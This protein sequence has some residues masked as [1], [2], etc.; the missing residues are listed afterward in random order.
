MALIV[1]NSDGAIEEIQRFGIGSSSGALNIAAGLEIPSNK[2]HTVVSL[3]SGSIL[4]EIKAEPF[5]PN[6]P[7]Y[8]APGL[9][10]RARLMAPSI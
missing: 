10:T 6:M 9:Q 3:V 5:D 1:F 4:L 2:W 8:L 7:K